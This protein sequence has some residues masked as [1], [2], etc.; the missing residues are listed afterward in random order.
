MALLIPVYLSL[1]AFAAS[2]PPAGLCADTAGWTTRDRQVLGTANRYFVND[3]ARGLHAVWKHDTGSISYNFRP[4]G[5]A[6]RWPGGTIVNQRPRNL[7]GMDVDLVSGRALL[8]TDYISRGSPRGSFYRDSAPGAGRFLETYLGRGWRQVLAAT[9][10]YGWARFA[11]LRNDSVSYLLQLSHRRLGASSM[12]PTHS[13][14]GARNSSRFCYLWTQGEHPD[15]G[16]LML[17]ETP[18]NGQNWY[19]TVNLSDSS[20]IPQSRAPHGGQAVYDSIQLYVVTAFTDGEDP[21]HSELWCYAKYETP[22]WYRI[23][24]HRV[25]DTLRLGEFAL[26]AG[27]PTMGRNPRTGELFVAWE[28]FDADN[29]EP[30]TG[31]ARADIWVARSQDRGRSWG[32]PV[33]LTGPDSMSRR[34]PY[35][36]D[37]VDDTLRILCFADRYAGFS[38][39]G[40]GPLTMNPVLVLSLPADELPSAVVSRLPL[41][42]DNDRPQLRPTIS[43]RG[44]DLSAPGPAIIR[45]YCPAG[46]LRAESRVVSP[47]RNWGQELEPGVWFVDVIFDSRGRESGVPATA[48]RTFRVVRLP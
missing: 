2:S 6:W 5:R 4:R 43:R 45:A 12:F 40:Q 26:A 28:Q 10:R 7:G 18:N 39:Q 19:V 42:L 9:Q 31:L 14:T 25:P 36:A 34:F 23:H 41:E 13:V 27:R 38:E 11:A 30:A 20:R 48:K 3:P 35:L 17:K 47:V 1:V 24:E 44:F 8:G 33:R 37:I 15:V 22:E 29:I 21:N 32:T 16:A 46:R